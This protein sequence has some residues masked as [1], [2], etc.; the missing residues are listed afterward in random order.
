MVAVAYDLTGSCAGT[1][2]DNE[3]VV[4]LAGGVWVACC[5]AFTGFDVDETA[6]DMCLEKARV[7][8]VCGRRTVV[9]VSAKSV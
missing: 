6:L 3:E 2:P 4:S 7:G 1:A 5:E 8:V 9:R